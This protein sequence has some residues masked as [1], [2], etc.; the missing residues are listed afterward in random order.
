MLC[1]LAE[2]PSPVKCCRKATKEQIV[3]NVIFLI[4]IGIISGCAS[5]EVQQEKRP[6]PE[7]EG[8]SA[9]GTDCILIGTIRDYTPLDDSHLII[10]G[11][12]R[13]YLVRIFSRTSD[14]RTSY[15]MSFKSRDDQLC[16]YGG[17][18]LVFGSMAFGSQRIDSI[19]RLTKEQAKELQDFYSKDPKKQK[20]L[21]PKE[22]EGADV[23]ELG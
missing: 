6:F 5:S 9:R 22:L 16:P 19:Q 20:A 14:L 21:E 13:P 15:Q 3:K 8:L 11:G 7:L 23:E 4:V 1:E 17:D 18:E 10:W 12:S 2:R